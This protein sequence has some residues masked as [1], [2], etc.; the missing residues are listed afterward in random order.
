[1]KTLETTLY[2]IRVS[3]EQAT[4]GTYCF[5]YLTTLIDGET[6]V[7]NNDGTPDTIIGNVSDREDDY[8]A[9]DVTSLEEAQRIMKEIP[10]FIPDEDFTEE[11]A[12]PVNF[13]ANESKT[14]TLTSG[15]YGE[16]TVPTVKYN[17]AVSL[18]I[19]R[20]LREDKDEID[21]AALDEM[22]YP[23]HI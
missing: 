12:P 20:A 19:K 6:W 5:P 14:T 3:K 7:C 13:L 17:T 21:Y 16:Y 23:Y 1:M 2:D 10:C 8:Y 11:L 9:F 4:D 18:L 22:L 15:K